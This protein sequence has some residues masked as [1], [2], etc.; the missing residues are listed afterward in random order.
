M[1]FMGD[2]GDFCRN[3]GHMLCQRA[4]VVILMHLGVVGKMRQ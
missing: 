3:I 4:T 1:D 2:Y